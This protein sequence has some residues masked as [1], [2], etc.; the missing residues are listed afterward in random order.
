MAPVPL[1]SDLGER[2]VPD[3]AAAGLVA[4]M[5]AAASE[6][7]RSAAGC[8]ITLWTSTVSIVG[9]RSQWLPLPGGPVRS[10]SLVE[11]DGVEVTGWRLLGGRLWSPTPWSG[12]IPVEVSVTM[13]HGFDEVPADIVALCRDLAMAGINSALAGE[14]SRGGYQSDTEAID[15]YSHS[16]TF[17]TG[18][19]AASGVMELTSASRARLAQ[20]FGGGAYVVGGL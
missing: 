14:G 2:T 10:V 18:R 17:V 19:D 8:P 16:R 3:G 9:P 1:A 12:C 7:I 11:A 5:L 15:D 13:T 6:E 4:E 20:R